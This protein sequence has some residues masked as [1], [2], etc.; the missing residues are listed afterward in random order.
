MGV[1]RLLSDPKKFHEEDP[2]HFGFVM[3]ALAGKLGVRDRAGY[4]EAVIQG[5]QSE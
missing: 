3:A 4:R 5:R 1:E 2:Q